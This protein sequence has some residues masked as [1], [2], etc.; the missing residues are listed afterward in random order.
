[1]NIS[2]GTLKRERSFVEL[3][4]HLDVPPW[5]IELIQR[6]TAAAF[7]LFPADF[8]Q[9]DRYSWV[10]H[11]TVEGLRATEHPLPTWVNTDLQ[12]LVLSVLVQ[13]FDKPTPS[14]SVSEHSH[15]LKD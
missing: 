4:S 14:F 13:A 8:Q 1:M 12:R 9:I 10:L 11:A 5:L 3:P 15:P 2:W 6:L 7:L